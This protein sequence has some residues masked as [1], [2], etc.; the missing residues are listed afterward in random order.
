VSF[1]SL[2]DGDRFVNP[3]FFMKAAIRSSV[4]TFGDGFGLKLARSIQNEGETCFTNA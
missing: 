1:F 2:P 4:S 3:A